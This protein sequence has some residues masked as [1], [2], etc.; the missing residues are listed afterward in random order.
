MN[1]AQRKKQEQK[2]NFSRRNF[3]KLS[4]SA[5]GLL[6]AGMPKGWIGGAY[7]AEG[8]PTLE[9]FGDEFRAMITPDILGP[10]VDGDATFE[11][12]DHLES[13]HTAAD[14][15]RDGSEEAIVFSEQW[16]VAATRS[17]DGWKLLDDLRPVEEAASQQDQLEIR[18]ALKASRY[19]IVNPPWQAI[20][21]N[22]K[23]YMVSDR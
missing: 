7:A 11:H 6:L 10:P 18:D 8:Q 1:V 12:V 21:I 22:G 16:V 3:L 19:R 14:L 17:P 23:T 9:R 2:T 13:I 5:V 20:E 15:N 4:G